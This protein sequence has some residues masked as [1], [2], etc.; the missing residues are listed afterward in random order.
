ME[1]KDEIQQNHLPPSEEIIE[2]KP[3][4][5]VETNHT[6]RSNKQNHEEAKEHETV[7]DAEK[8]GETK[9]AKQA[10]S[11]PLQKGKAK[12]GG[13]Q[14]KAKP[15]IPQ[16]FSLAT[17]RRMSSRE[18]RN[19]VDSDHPI[20]KSTSFNYKHRY[21]AQTSQRVERSAQVRLGTAANKSTSP[22]SLPTDKP[23]ENQ[24]EEKELE[25]KKPRKSPTLKAS[26]LSS[27]DKKA[28]QNPEL[29]KIP[30][31]RSLL[32]QG[33][34]S[35]SESLPRQSKSISELSNNKMEA[36][37]RSTSI[38]KLR[39]NK[40]EAITENSSTKINSANTMS[41]ESRTTKPEAIHRRSKSISELSINK[42]QAFK[43]SK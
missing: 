25:L 19:G 43:R 36:F 42:M 10:I 17:E 21:H 15:T 13:K 29:K 12:V 3:N 4:N 5:G 33:N 39:N 1:E 2:E 6:V 24:Q 16:P 8:V 23:T 20:L 35:I 41:S 34:R 37:K 18:K 11:S 27:F 38:S 9:E 22:R 40:M 14:R 31:T 30:L 32:H 7:S 28:P 26:P